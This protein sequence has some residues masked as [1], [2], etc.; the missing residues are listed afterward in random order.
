ME[1]IH[2]KYEAPSPQSDPSPEGRDLHLSCGV[3]RGTSQPFTL[4]AEGR[5]SVWTEQ[6]EA[7]IW[8]LTTAS[9]RAGTR[10]GPRREPAAAS[11]SGR[12]QQRKDPP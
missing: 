9:E 7:L 1:C 11:I 4:Q 3:D 10:I 8:S 2:V 5:P 12:P 6:R